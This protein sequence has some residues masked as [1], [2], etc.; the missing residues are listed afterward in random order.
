M[1]G[2]PGNKLS[3]C[4]YNDPRNSVGPPAFFFPPTPLSYSP[5]TRNTD[6]TN[7]HPFILLF[8]LAMPRPEHASVGCVR[9]SLNIHANDVYYESLQG[10]MGNNTFRGGDA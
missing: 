1:V 5:L 10:P 4:R 3:C 9:R 6:P 7:N 2:S 8:L